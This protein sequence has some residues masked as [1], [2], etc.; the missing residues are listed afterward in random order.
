MRWDAHGFLKPDPSNDGYDRADAAFSRCC[1]FS[2]LAD[3][4]DA[5]AAERFPDAGVRDP[6]IGRFEKAYVGAVAE[7]E[8]RARGSSGG[9]VSWVAAE[10]LRREEI[11]AVIH[12]RPA[13]AQ[14]DGRFFTYGI[15]RSPEEIAE[16]AKSRYYPVDLSQALR[17]VRD[18]ERRYAVVGVPCFIKAVHLLRR[19]DPLLSRR[20]THT[21]GLF[22]G[23]MKSAHFVQSFA[24][25][26][27]AQLAEVRALD[28]R[29]KN[30]DRPANWYRA[31]LEL[32]S[33]GSVAEDWWQLA[34]GDW[35]AG[36]FQNPACDVCDDVVAET[37]DI[38]FGDAWVEPH[39]SDGRGTNV[40][41]VRRASLVATIDRAVAEGRLDLVPVDADFVAETQAAGLRH[42]REGLAYR[43]SWNKRRLQP[44]KRISPHLAGSMPARRQLVFRTR[45]AIARWSHRVMW[46]ARALDASFLYLVWARFWL[47]LYQGLAW[48][49]GRWGVLF[50]RIFRR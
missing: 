10:L 38:S 27:G 2:P 16:G 13:D 14:R 43:L 17:E 3:D 21:L 1:P 20:I 4:E 46:L 40:V 45:A 11:D 39:S 41:I 12:V 9:M 18:V 28:Y 36:F 19:A 22:C 5:L 7:G 8:W 47:R 44:R 37:A 15:S 31:R 30:P 6:R 34:D 32:A 35:G 33:G 29:V 23:H 50:D 42:R 48:S 25:Q 49:N 26:L 24:W